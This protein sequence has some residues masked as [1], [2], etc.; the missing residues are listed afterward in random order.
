MENELNSLLTR[1]GKLFFNYG[2][3]SLTMDDI[4]RELGI[5]KKTLYQY[6]SNKEDLVEKTLNNLD[7]EKDKEFEEN[8]DYTLNAVESLWKVNFMVSKMIREQNPSAEYDLKKYYPEIFSK[9]RVNRMEKIKSMVINNIRQGKKE[10]LYR[11][12]VDETLIAKFYLSR[13]NHSMEIDSVFTHEELSDPN[14][15]P[16]VIQ[17]HIRG[18]ANNKG[19]KVLEQLLLNEKSNI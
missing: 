4:A 19:I 10:G 7:C 2:I 15:M 12:D 11:E 9:F 14:F 18:I 8:V 17:Y 3:K 16:Q 5:S 13:I 6:V 1:V